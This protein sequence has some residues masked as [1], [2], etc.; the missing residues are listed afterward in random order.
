MAARPG[1]IKAEIIVPFPRTRETI[2]SRAFLD[3]KRKRQALIR[4]EA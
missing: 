3:R 4:E 1:R 2:S